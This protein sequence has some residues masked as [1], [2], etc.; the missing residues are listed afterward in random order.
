MDM[1]EHLQDDTMIIYALVRM[2]TRGIYMVVSC[3]LLSVCY[4]YICSQGKIQ[5]LVYTSMRIMTY[6]SF[7]FARFLR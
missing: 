2:H 1:Q 5:V 4:Q 7:R 6:F 3:V